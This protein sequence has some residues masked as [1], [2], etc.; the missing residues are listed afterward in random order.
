M[1]RWPGLVPSA[2]RGRSPGASETNKSLE[3]RDRG[4]RETESAKS[5]TCECKNGFKRKMEF[6][7]KVIHID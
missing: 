5:S 2:E 1:G 6:Q 3:G 7:V 4:F